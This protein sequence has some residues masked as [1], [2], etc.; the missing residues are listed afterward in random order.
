MPESSAAPSP[1]RH[2]RFR[3]IMEAAAGTSTAS[4]MAHP[5]FWNLPLADL[6]G[7]ELYGVVL[8]RA[9][10]TPPADKPSGCC[11]ADDHG[12]QTAPAGGSADD[13]GLIRGL[14]GQY[15]F[16]GT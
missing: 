2:E 8:M 1:S 14:R 12:H 7:F 6:R 16:D 3:A 11:H 10:G 9:G 5:R 15:P 4:Y 13:A